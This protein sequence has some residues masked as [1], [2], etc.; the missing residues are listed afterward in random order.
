MSIV[1]DY[2]AGVRFQKQLYAFLKEIKPLVMVETG[3]ATGVSS[4]WVAQ[5]M[6][7]N[8]KGH[9]W[10][11]EPFYEQNFYHERFT[12]VRG[13]STTGILSSFRE[14]GPFDVFLHDSDHEAGCQTYEYA[15]GYALLKPGG[16]LISDDTEWGTPPHHSWKKLRL[17]NN[18]QELILGCARGVQKPSNASP[19]GS[20]DTFLLNAH[21]RALNAADAI[22]E[23]LGQRSYTEQCSSYAHV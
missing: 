13:L 14:S 9:L 21:L 7:E 16:W 12:F 8:Q 2:T 1:L 4:G 5:A 3:V 19:V 6:E 23:A 10:G 15:L 17:E 22:C 18:L 11:I 20:D